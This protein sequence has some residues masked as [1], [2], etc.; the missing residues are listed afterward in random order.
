MSLSCHVPCSSH[1]PIPSRLILSRIFLAWS[2]LSLP[3]ML[4]ISHLQPVAIILGCSANILFMYIPIYQS[5][6]DVGWLLPL[7][8]VVYLPSAVDESASTISLLLGHSGFESGFSFL[9]HS[10][11][12]DE[13]VGSAFFHHVPFH[14][15]L[16]IKILLSL[17]MVMCLPPAVDESS[18]MISSLLR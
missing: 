10:C 15:V 1:T 18:S 17:T 16:S 11:T 2:Y 6:W 7:A 4:S 8:M 14:V 13:A 12:N 9:R 5:H 3:P